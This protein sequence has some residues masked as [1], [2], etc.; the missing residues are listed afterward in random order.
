MRKVVAVASEAVVE[1]RQLSPHTGNVNQ[2][3]IRKSHG[4][5]QRKVHFEKESGDKGLLKGEKVRVDKGLA[6]G[7]KAKSSSS[8]LRGGTRKPRWSV[9]GTVS[10]DDDYRSNQEN[11]QKVGERSR[12]KTANMRKRS[13]SFSEGHVKMTRRLGSEAGQ[14]LL[15]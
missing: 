15:T 4:E 9:G 1:R 11:D 13:Y 3:D 14:K 7:E 2:Q 5:D 12:P 10:G 8:L 6:R